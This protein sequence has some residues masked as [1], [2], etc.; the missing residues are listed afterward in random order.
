MTDLVA[1]Q[2]TNAQSPKRKFS[3]RFPNLTHSSHE[4]EANGQQNNGA[5]T[6]THQS[7]GNSSK[8]R[9]NFT[10]EVKNVPDLQVRK[11]GIYSNF[12]L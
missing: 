8:E 6:L 5:N 7:S 4:K 1:D 10:E 2:N 9:K 11:F 12:L 3:F